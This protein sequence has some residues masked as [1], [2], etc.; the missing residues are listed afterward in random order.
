MNVLSEANY[1]HDKQKDIRQLNGLVTALIISIAL[2]FIGVV[3]FVIGGF[4]E[5]N[6]ELF[7]S[8]G[9]FLLIVGIVSTIVLSR[10]IVSLRK[11]IKSCCPKSNNPTL[12]YMNS[13]KEKTGVT[14]RQYIASRGPVFSEKVEVNDFYK[15]K[16]CG[17]NTCHTSTLDEYYVS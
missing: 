9:L 10:K 16:T 5:H 11:H 12:V 3:F 4:V 7:F 14:N 1:A 2:I 6:Y 15:C 17:H 13:T 8:I